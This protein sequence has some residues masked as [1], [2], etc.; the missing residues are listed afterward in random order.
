MP[1]GKSRLCWL[2]ATSALFVSLLLGPIAAIYLPHLQL[3]Y[4]SLTDY[5]KYAGCVFAII[6]IGP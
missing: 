1:L 4:I 3:L 2:R 6:N 5:E